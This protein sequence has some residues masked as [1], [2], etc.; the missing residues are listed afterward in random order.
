V[1]KG[2]DQIAKHRLE[3]RPA[4]TTIA[5]LVGTKPEAH[6][7]DVPAR[8]SAQNMFYAATS[9]HCSTDVRAVKELGYGLL[10]M[11]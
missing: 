4:W 10:P 8:P 7:D 6:R 11:I 2:V 3:R 1:L 9:A 5:L